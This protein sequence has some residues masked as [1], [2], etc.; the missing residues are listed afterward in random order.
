ME[1][2]M[3]AITNGGDVFATLP[4]MMFYFFTGRRRKFDEI[5]WGFALIVLVVGPLK[6][7]VAEQRPCAGCDILSFPSFHAANSFMLAVALSGFYP[8]LTILIFAAATLVSFTRI[9]LNVHYWT[10]VVA[11]AAIGLVSG[12]LARERC[13]MATRE[14]KD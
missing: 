12:Y 7:I 2:L 11:G 10:D 6:L 8:H 4:I 9:Y 13:K 1:E 3:W 14:Q 5:L